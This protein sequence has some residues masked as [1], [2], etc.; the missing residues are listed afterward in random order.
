MTS[1]MNASVAKAPLPEE[2]SHLRTVGHRCFPSSE[3]ECQT[4]VVVAATGVQFCETW[5]PSEVGWPPPAEQ[6][7]PGR[8]APKLL[9]GLWEASP[10]ARHCR[11]HW[12]RCPR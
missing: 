10:L 4:V 2:P 12:G 9:A 8:V 7:Q 6:R 1:F 3:G 11:R 5:F